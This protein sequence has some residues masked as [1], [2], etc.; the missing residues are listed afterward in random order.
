MPA[1]GFTDVYVQIWDAWQAGDHKKAREIF[2]H[3][4]PLINLDELVDQGYQPVMHR[5]G[6]FKTAVSRIPHV[7][8][9]AEVQEEID[10]A[11]EDVKPYLRV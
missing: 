8:L 2:M 1:A 10:A 7:A 4:L 3:L 5:R 6:V 9:S 11:Y